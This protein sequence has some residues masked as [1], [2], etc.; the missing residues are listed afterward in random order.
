VNGEKLFIRPL[1]FK[2]WKINPSFPSLEKGGIPLFD[3]LFLS[4][5]RQRGVRGD[6]QS[7]IS[8]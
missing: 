6:F 8:I 5:D 3:I 2:R 4:L 7:H 1:L